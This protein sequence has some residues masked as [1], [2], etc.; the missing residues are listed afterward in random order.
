MRH[1]RI[2]RLPYLLYS[3]ALCPRLPLPPSPRRIWHWVLSTPIDNYPT[4]SATRLVDVS[5]TTT[6]TTPYYVYLNV[7]P[8]RYAPPD[9]ACDSP[10]FLILFSVA[11]RLGVISVWHW[12][13]ADYI[14]PAYVF[15]ETA[16]GKRTELHYSCRSCR[17][18]SPHIHLFVPVSVSHSLSLSFS[19]SLYILHISVYV[20]QRVY[21]STARPRNNELFWKMSL[22]D[23][24]RHLLSHSLRI[25]NPLIP[26]WLSQP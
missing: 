4:P 25:I 22:S 19:V 18:P 10:L 2:G 21:I 6:Y 11:P 14:V 12:N 5:Y 8:I 16:R 7:T 9:A 26:I 20:E 24:S 23:R 17:R 13:C 15:N 1:A 3:F